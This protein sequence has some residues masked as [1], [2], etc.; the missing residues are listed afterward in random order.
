MTSSDQLEKIGK[1]RMVKILKSGKSQPEVA[2]DLGV[3]Q[4]E[5][6]RY[7]SKNITKSGRSDKNYGNGVT[8]TDSKYNFLVLCS[9]VE[10]HKRY[11]VSKSIKKNDG[12]EAQ[13]LSSTISKMLELAGDKRRKVLVGNVSSYAEFQIPYFQMKLG[14][15]RSGCN[16]KAVIMT[17]SRSVSKQSTYTVNNYEEFKKGWVKLMHRLAVHHEFHCLPE[18]WEI[19]DVG[20]YEYFK[21][22]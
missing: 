15:H 17:L 11:R 8:V 22:K 20:F 5:L 12:S 2:A 7:I 18:E 1:S 6:K 14:R 3:S 4:L 10:N 16:S 19:P 13:E 21:N 9:Y